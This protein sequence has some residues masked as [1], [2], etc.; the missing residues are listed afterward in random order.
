MNEIQ[1]LDNTYHFKTYKRY[2]VTLVKGVGSRVW[3][4]AGKEY[5]DCLAG[6]AVNNMGHCHPRIVEAI[7]IQA[8]ELMHVSNFFTTK[9]QVELAKRLIDLS[10]HD[11]IFF[12]NSGTE[13]IEGA[14]KIARRYA[15]KMGKAGPIVSMKGAFHGRSMG[16]LALSQPKYQD[17]FGEMLSGCIQVPFN[18]INAIE[19]IANDDLVAVFI[20]PVQGEGGI[21]VADKDYMNDLRALCS[22]YKAL[23]VFD[24]IQCG[25]GRSG[26][27]FAYEHYDV[28]P[29]VITLAKGLGGGF[30]IGAIIATEDTANI[31]EYGKHGTTFGGNPL[32]AAAAL[33]ALD[34]IEEEKLLKQAQEKGE[35]LRERIRMEMPGESG[36]SEVRGLGLMNGVQLNFKGAGV[37]LR[38]LEKGVIANVTA[39]D[40]VRLVP[41]LNIT[42][43]ELDIVVEAMIES[44]SEE[45]QVQENL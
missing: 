38:M 44:I 26:K 12:S 7:Q 42:L 9:P 40:V 23:L 33:A 30:P 11:R 14:V 39:S 16:A 43:K 8:A 1:E 22:E 28:I 4:D 10:N 36:I 17:G 34:V 41:P 25:I 29:D 15:S 5:V 20:E 35:W 32:A 27:F 13:A 21:H 19:A 24:E 6:I 45:R 3:D 2:P 31:I 18:D 37:A